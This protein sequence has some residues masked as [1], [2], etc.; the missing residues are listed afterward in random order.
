MVGAFWIDDPQHTWFLGHGPAA[1]DPRV[2][3]SGRRCRRTATCY[4][5]ALCVKSRTGKQIKPKIRDLSPS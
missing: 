2:P 3:A 5:G 4:L 1:Q